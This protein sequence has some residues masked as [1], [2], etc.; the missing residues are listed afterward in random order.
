MFMEDLDSKILGF[1]MKGSVEFNK[2]ERMLDVGLFVE[3]LHHPYSEIAK[4]IQSFYLRHK[5]PPSYT[6]LK[7]EFDDEY[8]KSFVES[9]E[10][11]AC[12][13]SEIGHYMEQLKQRFNKK[14]NED[15]VSFISSANDLEKVNSYTKQTLSKVEKLSRT[16]V[17]SEGEVKE[18]VDGRI[19]HYEFVKENPDEVMGVLSGYR[20]LDDYT[21]GLKNSEMEVIV[22]ASS[23]GKSMLMLNIA[24]NSWLG[25]NKPHDPLA[26]IKKDGKNVL[27]VSLEM[28]KDQLEGRLD[29][30]VAGI[31][32]KNLTRG[33]LDPDEMHRWK[34]SLRF[35]EQYD[36][37]FY[38]LDMPRGTKTL[39]IEARYESI[40]G[41][42]KPD[43]VCVDY[44][45]IMAPNVSRNSQDWL[46]VG[47][48]AADLHEFCRNKNIP[49]LTAAQR[50]AKNKN[51]KG[52]SN[53]LEDIGRS[54]MIGDNANIVLLINNR[55][56]ERLRE[57]MEVH[58]VKNRDGALGSFKLQKQFEKSKISSF[59]DN[60][61]AGNGSENEV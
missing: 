40:L 9:M 10:S 8:A 56:D 21:Y 57:D 51:V 3:A 42:F 49:V 12:E 23:S 14:L 11:E 32:H 7:Q 41:M 16:N 39:E 13:E 6:I 37:K 20:E 55:E 60:W 33:M 54:K 31:R 43:L 58:I 38:I 4:Y 15:L 5:V 48:V 35:I 18:T 30:C 52:E 29:A 53:D 61:S 28:S 46:D 27:Y 25:S 26:P 44:L 19:K 1:G 17:F 59:P 2:I 50:K 22:G 45:G 36:K 47:Y 34:S 24:I